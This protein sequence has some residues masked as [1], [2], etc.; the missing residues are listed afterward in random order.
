MNEVLGNENDN[1][2]F[3]NKT[4]SNKNVPSR[5]RIENEREY[6][7]RSMRNRSAPSDA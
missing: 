4:R 2:G 5:Q 7:N 3:W 6:Q 1:V